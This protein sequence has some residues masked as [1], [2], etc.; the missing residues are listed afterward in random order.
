MGAPSCGESVE[1]ARLNKPAALAE[2]DARLAR[3]LSKA[4]S[5]T[6]DAEQA[7]TAATSITSNPAISRERRDINR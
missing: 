4:P 5:L 2:L 6:P 7:A 3:R 1:T